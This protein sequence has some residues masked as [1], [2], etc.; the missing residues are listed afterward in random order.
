MTTVDLE[1]NDITL[2][3][4][5][6]YGGRNEWRDGRF[7]EYTSFLGSSLKEDTNIVPV[8]AL[9]RQLPAPQGGHWNRFLDTVGGVGGVPVFQLY[10]DSKLKNFDFLYKVFNREFM[11]K[12]NEIFPDSLRHHY[13]SY[14]GNDREGKERLK[15]IMGE[16]QRY[17]SLVCSSLSATVKETCSSFTKVP[18]EYGIPDDLPGYGGY[19]RY[20]EIIGH[21]LRGNGW[22][23]HMTR[24]WTRDGT[25]KYLVG[26]YFIADIT[27]RGE[28]MIPL[29]ALVTKSKYLEYIKYSL[30]MGKEIDTRVLQVWIHPLFDVPRSRWRGLR[31]YIR[32]QFLIPMYDAGVPIGEKE[33]FKELF[34]NIT[35]PHMTDLNEYR[36][37]LQECSVES[38]NN[39][40][41]NIN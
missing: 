20:V 21:F 33:S 28:D 22:Q 31:P 11:H 16:I 40:K 14:K 18:E 17:Y 41:T 4:G 35:I 38:I 30:A 6:A 3:G 2:L 34:K 29:V 37:W 13:F 26:S 24:T 36:K 5:R 1:K 23:V 25:L 12:L 27:K 10:D 39:L 32:K 7:I 8:F 9:N 15:E 19:W